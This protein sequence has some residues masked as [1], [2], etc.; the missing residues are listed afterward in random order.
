[1]VIDLNEAIALYLKHYPGGNEAEFASHYGQA[2]ATIKDQVQAILNEAMNVEA[3][4][5]RMSLN[6]AG[7]YVET[8]M[9]ERHPNL[10]PRTLQ[11]IGNYY[12]YQVR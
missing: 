5:N 9:H 6:D 3:D 11:A 8:V 1:M 4:W 12:T 7:D 10:K 2:A